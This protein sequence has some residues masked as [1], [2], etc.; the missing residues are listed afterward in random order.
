MQRQN[1]AGIFAKFSSEN[2]ANS[3]ALGKAI[4][5]LNDYFHG[6]AGAHASK[7]DAADG[8]LG[9]LEAIQNDSDKAMADAEL[10]ESR[11]ASEYNKLQKETEIVL[12]SRKA[13]QQARANEMARLGSVISDYESDSQSKSEELNA[14]MEYLESVLKRCTHKS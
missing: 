2:S 9:F 4:E 13:A 5:T 11:A 7:T 3:A 6:D 10:A 8:V 14:S 12:A 1:E